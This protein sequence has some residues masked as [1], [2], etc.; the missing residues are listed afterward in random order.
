LRAI[1]GKLRKIEGNRRKLGKSR[2]FEG[3]WEKSEEIE[4]N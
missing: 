1:G 4:G 2:E 3:N